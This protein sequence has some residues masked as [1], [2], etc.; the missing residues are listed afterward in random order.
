MTM[1]RCRCSVR[2]PVYRHHVCGQ[3]LRSGLKLGT[4]HNRGAGK[5]RSPISTVRSWPVK[6]EMRNPM[7]RRIAEVTFPG[8]HEAHRSGF[9]CRDFLP[10]DCPF[11]AIKDLSFGQASQDSSRSFCSNTD[12]QAP[13]GDK[14]FSVALPDLLRPDLAP[15]PR[16]A[17]DFGS[18]VTRW[19]TGRPQWLSR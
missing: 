11:E 12:R 8:H 4:K 18:C 7:T 13:P 16:Q 1:Y 2:P 5:I 15:W 3:W 9:Q 17:L 14:A 10:L 19:R 6:H